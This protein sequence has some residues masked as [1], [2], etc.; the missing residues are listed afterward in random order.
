MSLQTWQRAA[1]LTESD[2]VEGMC[3]ELSQTDLKAIGRSRQ[4]DPEIVGSR[5]LFQHVFLSAQ[6]VV[7]AAASLT[8]AELAGLQLLH[9][10]REAVDVE[11]FKRVYPAAVSPNL[12]AS[13]NDRFKALFQE[14]KTRLIQRGLLV[15]GLLPDTSLRGATL[16]ERRRFRFPE[17]FG[18]LLP[19]PCQPRRL[20]PAMAGSHRAEVLRDKLAELLRPGGAAANKPDRGET[21][22]WWLE[23]GEL[24][25]GTGSSGFRVEHLEAWQKAQFEA[26]VS[27]TNKAQP[28][29]LMPVPL[30]FYALSRLHEHEWLAPS[31]LL[32]LWHVALPGAKAPEPQTVC[33]AGYD[34]GCIERIELDGAPLYHLPRLLDREAGTPP[35]GFLRT[36][37][38]QRI[39]IRLATVPL[40]ALER[41]CEVSRLEL[42]EGELWASPNLLKLSHAHADTLADPMLLWL[43]EHHPAFRSTME[44]IEQ[45]RG[46][47]IVHE[48]LLV[49]RVRDLALKV[50]L[51]RQFGGPGKLVGLFGEFVA[52]PNALLP[53]LQA[54][55]KRSG[56]VIKRLDAD[57]TPSEA[58]EVQKD[59]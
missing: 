52:F 4:F 24:R 40:A 46:K 18:A 13:Y 10:L 19:P 59:E 48:N 38:P 6:G 29:A 39:G 32:P 55:M 22:C 37:N 44:K 34:W 21:G 30:L 58:V 50:M 25:L 16:L 42:A 5:E 3:L 8:P 27:Y 1:S 9:C 51:E 15:F 26:A 11:F 28:E 35:E 31:E 2:M 54:W 45:R 57:L 47:L 7:P 41:L 53:E 33:E 20:D 56:H 49:A 23:N 17:T 14:V 12:Y 36:D 43:R